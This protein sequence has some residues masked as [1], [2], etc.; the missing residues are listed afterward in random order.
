MT[1]KPDPASPE[2]G[3]VET[4]TFTGRL[5]ETAPF[6]YTRE[7]AGLF[8]AAMKEA[9]S[10]HIRGCPAFRGICSAEG[11][12]PDSIRRE[13]DIKRIP[14][15]FVSA[16]KE[17][18]LSSAPENRIELELTSS[19]TTGQKSRI[20][21]DSTSLLRVR[22]IAWQVFSALGM[23][24]LSSACDYL[25]FTYDPEVAKN[26]GT[27]WT[28]KLLTR[29]TKTGELYWAFKWNRD[30]KEFHFDINAAVEVLEKY[31]KKGR[32][33]RL[34]GFPAFAL[35]LVR[36]FEK[37]H[38]RSARLNPESRVI[39]GGGWKTEQDKAVEKAVMRAQIAEGLGIPP[40][41]MRDLFGMVEH[42]VPYVDCELGNF[43]VP[44]Y[45]RVIAR[46][47][48]TLKPLANGKTGLLQFMTP[49][50]TSYPSISLLSSDFGR[51][52]EKCA[53]GL[54]GPIMH[55]TGRAGVKKLK[56]CAIAAS[57]ML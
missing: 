3:P 44:V 31:E 42:G 19:G 26:L 24:D 52:E 17:R 50:L 15:I 5:I 28:D 43:H 6:D 30:K 32:P 29:F 38:G 45:S 14:F 2:C 41:H 37:K 13:A 47:P 25:C 40:G 7:S 10:R 53:C 46:D 49:Y 27:A 20:L 8:R 34:V 36:E 1:K 54:K 33:V 39:T 12:R 35:R 51:V 23:A 55:V 48:A 57:T 16:F 11:F 21:L 56:G 4:K 22:R 18:F 9:V